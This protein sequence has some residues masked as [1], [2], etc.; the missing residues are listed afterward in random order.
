MVASRGNT[1]GGAGSSSPFFHPHTPRTTVQVVKETPG[2]TRRTHSIPKPE[3]DEAKSNILGCAANLMNAIV[4]AGIVGI[5]Y[6]VSKTGLVAGIFLIVFCAIMT[7]KS[8]RLLVATAKHAHTASYETVAEAAFGVWGFRF[9]AINMGIMAYGAI[10]SYLLIVKQT[11]PTLL[12]IFDAPRQRAI[13]WLVSCLVVL[14][15]SCQRDMANLAFT[16]RISVV[17]DLLLVTM[18]VYNAPVLQNIQDHVQASGPDATFATYIWQHDVIRTETVFVGLGVLSFAFV[19]QHSAF[20]IAGSL[21][22]PTQKRWSM[23][24]SLALVCCCIL[25][26]AAGMTGYL[27]YGMNTAGNILSN[28]PHNTSSNVARLAMGTAMLFVYPMESFVARHVCISL[29]FQG[30]RAHEGNADA[31]I[32]NRWDRR[33]GLTTFLFLTAV[34]PASLVDN[35]G[36]VL[37]VTGCIGGSCLSYLGPGMIYLGIHGE[38]F[39]ELVKSSSWFGGWYR[40]VHCRGRPRE[41]VAAPSSALPSDKKMQGTKHLPRDTLDEITPLVAGGG[42]RPD[43]SEDINK[44]STEPS[45]VS[46]AIVVVQTIMACLCGM[47]LWCR[48]ARMGKNT[49]EH[50]MHDLALKSPYPLR[51]GDVEY[52]SIDSSTT[53]SSSDLTPVPSNLSLPSGDDLS[54]L[55]GMTG[56]SINQKIGQQLLLQQKQAANTKKV[57]KNRLSAHNVNAIEKDPQETPGCFDFIV[58]IGFCLVGV[59]ALVAGLVSLYADQ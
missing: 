23:V 55:S 12:G 36:N 58:A 51:I 40:Y 50:H 32:L 15:L 22:K 47:P 56:V 7:E 49:L 25:A 21:E 8:L 43:T 52:K 14:P 9:V 5:A 33:V 41:D 6:A 26:L 2:G 10:L 16:S 44:E 17:L 27:G 24:T 59:V 20:L 13:L 48:F 28:L 19:C 53:D 38:A 11:Y 37:A 46:S 34:I 39:L 45:T 30:R 31:D 54:A 42:R 1:S 4:G 35:L 57:L 29:F 18:V 3:I